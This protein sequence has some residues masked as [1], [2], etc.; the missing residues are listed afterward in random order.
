[1]RE[2]RVQPGEWV[3]FGQQHRDR[4]VSYGPL[5]EFDCRAGTAAE[6]H[7][8]PFGEQQLCRRVGAGVEAGE[9]LEPR[10]RRRAAA[11]TTVGVRPVP[12]TSTVNERGL[13]VQLPQRGVMQREQFPGPAQQG[14]TGRREQRPDG[15]CGP[16]AARRPGPPVA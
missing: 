1:M 11:S 2:A 13:A 12:T 5:L 6:R 8:E 4:F 9:E 16:A 14:V 7:V 3:A 10:H 15:S